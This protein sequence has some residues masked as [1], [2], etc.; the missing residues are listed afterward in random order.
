MRHRHKFNAKRCEEDGIKFA[1]KAERAYYDKLLILQKCGEVLFFLMQVPFHL[2]G[3]IKY[4]CDFEVF[5]SDGTVRFIDIKG[6][7]TP[8]FELKK[9]SVEAHYPIEIEI[10]K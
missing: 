2:P 7:S 6:F 1:S 4:I 5:Y 9:K 3:K 10:E 8:V